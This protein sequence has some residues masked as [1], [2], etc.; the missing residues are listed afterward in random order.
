MLHAYPPCCVVVEKLCMFSPDNVLSA[1]V[2]GL[3]TAFFVLTRFAEHP[4]V[5]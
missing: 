5:G 3:S 1:A 4:L 2:A